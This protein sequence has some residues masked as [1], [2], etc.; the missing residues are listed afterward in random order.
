MSDFELA[1]AQQVARV[2]L[3]ERALHDDGPWVF[4]T[5][6]HCDFAAQ[7]IDEE[8]HKVLFADTL[9]T[10]PENA[11]ETVLELLCGGQVVSCRTID[12][13][14]GYAAVEWELSLPQTTAV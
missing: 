8:N 7:Y 6:H 5:P 1:V 13:P 10:A 11:G 14:P 3:L 12:L 2:R 9:W 4:R